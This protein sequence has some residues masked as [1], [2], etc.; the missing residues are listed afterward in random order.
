VKVGILG[1]TFDPVHNGHLVIAEAIKAHLNL[2]EVVF[3]PAGQPW[4]KADRPISPAQ[5]RLEMLRLALA[6]KPYFKISAAEIERAGPSYTVD[7][8]EELKRQL[9]KAELF[10][11][12]GWD[13][14]ATLPRWHDAPRLIRLCTLV[15]VHRPGYPHPE[16]PPMELDVP[17]VSRRVIFMSEPC[18]D[19]SATDIRQKAR[20]GLP[21]N[22]LVP[23]AVVRYIKQR[24][25]YRE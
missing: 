19:I 2:D 25:L 8:V 1:G 17:G 14:L 7:T 21:V 13:S 9:G 16:L 4:L 18:V 10:F 24:G 6:G 20:Q 11:I 23:E 22:N 5:D 3:V 15:A 12:L